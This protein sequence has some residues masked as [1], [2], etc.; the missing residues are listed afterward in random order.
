MSTW[1]GKCAAG[2]T[3]EESQKRQAALDDLELKKKRQGLEEDI[4]SLNTS[5]EILPEKAEL[6]NNSLTEK[7]LLPL[8]SLLK[9][10]EKS[11]II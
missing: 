5:A 9:N 6:P 11:R 3:E 7:I 10:D 8:I 2:K 1:I 4:A